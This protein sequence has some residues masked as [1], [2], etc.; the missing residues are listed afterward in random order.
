MGYYRG[1]NIAN[2]VLAKDFFPMLFIINNVNC[3]IFAFVTTVKDHCLT[4]ESERHD[5]YLFACQSQTYLCEQ[6]F[7]YVSPRLIKMPHFTHSNTMMLSSGD[8]PTNLN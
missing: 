5:C 6:S 1:H 2:R 4:I 3:P 8:L 7:I